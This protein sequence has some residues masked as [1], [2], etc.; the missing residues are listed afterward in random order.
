MSRLTG[1]QIVVDYLIREGVEKVFA[2][3]G[4]GN[5]ALIDAFVDRKDEIEVI[6]AMHEQ[7]AAHMADGYYRATGKIAAC[8][9]SIG[10]GATNTLTGLTTAFSDSQP[11]L[12]ITGAVHTY[13]E[14]HG[15]LQ[16]ID[17]PHGNNFPRMAEPVVKRWWQPS[18]VDQLPT[19]LAQAFNTM[20]EGRRGP[21]L[22]DIPQDL[23]AEYGDYEPERTQRRRAHGRPVGDS[24][25]IAEAARLLADAK[26]PVILTGGGVIAAEA[27]AELLAVA[28]RLGA[29]VTHSF[30]GKGAFPADHDLYAWPCGDM[31]S[32]SGNGITRT[33]DVILA[34]GCRFSD[35]ITSSYKPGVT[36]NIPDTKLVQIDIDGFEIGRN[37]PAEVGI[38][39]DA[40]A[41]LAS[42][43]GELN[44]LGEAPDWRSSAY[45]AELQDLKAQWDEHLRP[46]RT[47]DHLP[48]TNS[49]AMVEIR[50]ALPRE[51]ILVTDSSNPAN[52]AFNEFPIYG[53]RTNIVAGGMSGIGFGLPA[54]VG[55][56]VAVGD[57][58][59]LALVGDGSFLQTG[60]ELA[61][62]VMLDLPLVVVVLNNGGWEAIKDLQIN[63]FGRERQIVSGWTTKDGKP[64]FANITEFAQSLGCTAERVEDP[65]KLEDAV[66]RA[67]E[68]QGPVV[69]EAMSAH[70]L[71]WTEMHPTGWWDITVPAYHGETRDEYVSQRGF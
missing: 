33:A 56:Q 32:V 60:T 42:L 39:G 3:P 59:V 51:G 26:R 50:K 12:L 31:G 40:K 29:P 71:P 48:M 36:F 47:T 5:T 37:Y 65:A 6:P 57:Q 35:R 67:F 62:A 27:T 45:F 13:M 43:L 17:R 52:Q 28:E 63:L 49:R 53:P 16:E 44:Q 20:Y 64:Y 23:Q 21:V 70:E 24:E 34:V 25:R 9:T 14:N 8:C 61:T 66:R 22:L 11:F 54:A 46:M 1:G 4:H 19:V 18:R 38:V 41:S 15:V 2:V 30:M 55:A 69:I 10:P 68:T 58:P 7:G